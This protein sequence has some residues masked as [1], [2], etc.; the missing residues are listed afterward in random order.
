MKSISKFLLAYILIYKLENIST[1]PEPEHVEPSSTYYAKKPITLNL[2]DNMTT[3]QIQY[4]YDEETNT[5]TF[6]PKE[7]YELWE[8]VLDGPELKE[9]GEK[10]TW[11]SENSSTTALKV[12]QNPTDNKDVHV[13]I[14]L[15]NGDTI[16]FFTYTYYEKQGP[17][18]QI[19]KTTTINQRSRTSNGGG[20]LNLPFVPLFD[21]LWANYIPYIF[22]SKTKVHI[23]VE[24][25]RKL[26]ETL[27]DSLKNTMDSRN[28]YICYT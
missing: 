6:V 24:K 19:L 3:S 13:K 17:W 12:V 21:L 9:V 16:S 27:G 11:R 23:H 2:Y 1:F 26:E 15:K 5:R 10:K 25:R 7:G 14:Y 4:T 22:T 28:G 8:V 20:Y 18:R